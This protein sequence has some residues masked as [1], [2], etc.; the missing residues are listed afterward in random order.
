MLNRTLTALAVSSAFLSAGCGS[1]IGTGSMASTGVSSSS[2][3]TTPDPPDSTGPIVR[4]PDW[5]NPAQGTPVDSLAAAQQ[6]IK[7]NAIQPSTAID[8]QVFVTNTTM[9][10][11]YRGVQFT[12]NSPQ[13]GQVAVQESPEDSSV[14]QWQSD[15]KS[16]AAQTG[17]P[18]V[19]GSGEVVMITPGVPALIT[20]TAD[21]ARSDIWWYDAG[22]SV[23]VEGPK[24]DKQAVV[25]LAD[26]IHSDISSNSR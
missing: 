2:S 17:Q 15:I 13:Y 19:Y 26:S 7:L 18:G 22:L 1:A 8:P 6:A 14:D 11:Q 12:W 3:S 9:D 5:N 23:H 4:E 10:A 21:G 25:E 24:L 16:I 20:T